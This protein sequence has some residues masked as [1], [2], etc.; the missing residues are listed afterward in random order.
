MNIHER[1]IR[2]GYDNSRVLCPYNDWKQKSLCLSD[3]F[4][5]QVKLKVYTEK[6]SKRIVLLYLPLSAYLPNSDEFKHSWRP[7]YHN[8]TCFYGNLL[9]LY[10]W[11]IKFYLPADFYYYVLM[12]KRMLQWCF[13]K[14]RLEWN[15]SR[16]K[17]CPLRVF[18]SFRVKRAFE[19]IWAAFE[20]QFILLDEQ[21]C[22]PLTWTHLF[23]NVPRW[24]YFRFYLSCLSLKLPTPQTNVFAFP[25]QT[26]TLE[27]LFGAINCSTG[28]DVLLA[29]LFIE[30]KI[31]V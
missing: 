8:Y 30:K 11:F 25:L 17:V 23:I 21:S 12:Y 26:R 7:N 22:L 2:V 9:V 6:T 14:A 18:H 13:K 24:H 4:H 28:E 3:R 19:C 20:Y 15:F 16:F 27:E 31:S 1:K 5:K 10:F 29:M